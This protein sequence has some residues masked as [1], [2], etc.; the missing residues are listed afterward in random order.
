MEYE[1]AAESGKPVIA[2]LH[3]DP[4]SLPANQTESDPDARERLEEF[5]RVTERKMVKYWSTPTD[6]G[7]VVS[8]S[9]IKLIKTHP[10]IGW[11]RGDQLAAESATAEMLELRKKIEK[12]EAE[13]AEA[14]ASRPEGIEDLAQENDPVKITVEAAYVKRGTFRPVKT[15]TTRHSTTWNRLFDQVAPM[16][17][18]EA[19]ETF[20]RQTVASYANAETR[21]VF[22]REGQAQFGDEYVISA[23]DVA[24]KDF[25][26]LKV[27]FLALGLVAQSHKKTRSVKDSSTYWTLTPAGE[28]LLL[29][30]RA[31]KK[32]LPDPEAE[33]AERSAS[34]MVGSGG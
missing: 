30:M 24:D 17:I 8:R 15:L 23:I 12:L 33:S 14:R 16:M 10:A 27:Q 29:R 4:G 20:I 32:E 9:V 25:D 7:S 26:T 22:V 6:L 21:H 31:V 3:K 28:E 11:V 34:L 13:L 1:Y 2:F 5:R 19:K 18:N